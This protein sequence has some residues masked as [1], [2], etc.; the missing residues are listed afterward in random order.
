MKRKPLPAKSRLTAF[1]EL[2]KPRITVLILVSTAL[3]Y[4]LGKTIGKNFGSKNFFGKKKFSR[5]KKFVEKKILEKKI[6]PRRLFFANFF[7]I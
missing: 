2:T 7:K 3:G 1:I 4:Y 6:F 5:K